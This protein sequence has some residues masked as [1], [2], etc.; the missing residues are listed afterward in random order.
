[1]F[2]A[3][4]QYDLMNAL[5][6]EVSPFYQ[7][8][9]G[10]LQNGLKKLTEL[11]YIVVEQTTH[12]KRKKNLYAITDSGKKAFIEFMIGDISETKYEAQTSTRLFFMGFANHEERLIIVDKIIE[13]LVNRLAVFEA[14]EQRF[15]ETQYDA[16]YKDNVHY[17]FKTLELGI[18][19]D[20]Q[21][22]E[23]FRGL[24]E[25]IQSEK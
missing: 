3:L 12:G 1:M 2:K 8:S 15:R 6:E 17:Q 10:S 20:R 22:I 19:Q 11:G 9:M 14:G 21:M 23:W 16:K 5:K 25:E 24:R 7:P 18:F 4:S 13:F